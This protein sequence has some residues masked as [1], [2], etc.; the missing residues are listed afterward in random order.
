MTTYF[1]R[2]DINPRRR[3]SARLLGSPN[4]MHGAVNLCFPPSRAPSR[5]LWRVDQTPSGT[6][7]YLVSDVAP[8][9]TG[10]VE[11][12]GWPLAGG[13]QTRDYGVVLDAVRAGAAFG[14]RLAANPVHN[15]R[16]PAKA[17]E[18]ERRRGVRLAH[19]TAAQQRAW[20]LDR[21]ASWGIDVG[22]GED[23]TVQ[24]VERRVV[25]FPRQGRQVTI[26]T[27]VF[28]GQLTVTEP[29]QLRRRLVEGIGPAKAYGCGL[30]TLAP[31]G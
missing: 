23:A 8:D 22:E 11:E 29:T 3:G 14:F 16:M 2:V 26:G 9:P 5:P 7:L 4:F 19:V 20:F 24:V 13:W 1:T 21:A 15:V 27:A 31:L 12:Y 6:V 10:F 17:G 30:M 25:K 18:D 28:E